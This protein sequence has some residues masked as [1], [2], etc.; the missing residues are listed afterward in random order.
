MLSLLAPRAAAGAPAMTIAAASWA[1]WCGGSSRLFSG[2]T[3]AAAAAAEQPP[4]AGG[5]AAPDSSESSEDERAATLPVEQLA[6]ALLA[7]NA[8][9]QLTTVKAGSPAHDQSKVS[10]SVVPY[11]CPKGGW[12]FSLRPAMLDSP[13]LLCWF[14]PLLR[15]RC[16]WCRS[17][18]TA[19]HP[20]CQAAAG[21]AFV[22]MCSV[23]VLLAWQHAAAPNTRRTTG[24]MYT[25]AAAGEAPV[26]LL[27]E[28]DAEHLEN[29]GQDAKV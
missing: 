8:R 5:A 14:V 7:G 15:G 4:A 13:V 9:G 23:L 25:R 18:G 24:I 16:C 26:V 6:K 19:Q 12:Q 29:L 17:P 11:L 28:Q 10:S 21:L 3:A 2:T 22:P 27:G 1:G 20:H